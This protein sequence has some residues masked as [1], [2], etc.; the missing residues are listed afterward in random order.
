M[1]AVSTRWLLISENGQWVVWSCGCVGACWDSCA[2]SSGSHTPSHTP[3]P[4][5]PHS[6]TIPADTPK[7]HRTACSVIQSGDG[8]KTFMYRFFCFFNIKIPQL[9]LACCDPKWIQH[10]GF[11]HQICQKKSLLNYCL[12]YYQ[13][14]NILLVCWFLNEG[15]WKRVNVQMWRI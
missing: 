6:L 9:Q 2:P 10:G 14:A 1:R 7:H 5:Q 12:Y 3:P 8:V 11:I 13:N 4:T 15:V